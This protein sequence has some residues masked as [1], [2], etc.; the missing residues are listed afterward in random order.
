MLHN[1]AGDELTHFSRGKRRRGV[2]VEDL[3]PLTNIQLD[4]LPHF[5]VRSWVLLQ[6]V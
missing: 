1:S 6:A 5:Q 4:I 3:K 2:L